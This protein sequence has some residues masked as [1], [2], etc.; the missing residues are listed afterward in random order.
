[1]PLS[2]RRWKQF[3]ES[4]Y[5]HE[6]EAL[7]FLREI[8]P[9]RD[10]IFLYSNFEFIAD[11]GSVNEIDALAVTQAGIFLIELKSRGG[12]VTGNRHL[13]DWNK[14][15]HTITVDSPLALTNSK[16]RKLAS[17]LGRQKSFRG[18]RAPWIEALVFLSAPGISVRLSDSE[19]MR[20]CEREP[21]DKKPGIAAALLQREYYGNESAR[22][23]FLDL[24][25]A[26]RFAKALEEAGIRP[27]QRQRRVGDY[28]LKELIEENPLFAYQDFQAE[29]PTTKATR[30]VRLY[31]V[32]GK[33][34]GTHEAV[35]RAALQEFQILEALDHPGILRAL[36]F[37]EHELGPAILFRRDS[38]EVRL[39]HFLRQ[40]GEKLPLDIRLNLVR[41]IADAVRYAHSH[42]VVHRTL[43]PKSILV[44]NPDSDRP[45][46]RLFNWQAGR[47]LATGSTP[48]TPPS[49]TSTL[50]PSQFSEE[51]MLC[52]LAPESV[53][54]PRGRDPMADVF[55]LGAVA[56]HIF[57][58][59]T[60]AMNGA[61]LNQILTEHKGLSLS[62]ALD[63]ANSGLQEL[64]REATAPDLL[65]RTESARDFLDNLDRA[66]NELTAPPQE[67][68]ADPL[69]ARPRDLLPH[70]LRVLKRLGGGT[71][72]VALLVERGDEILVLKYAR[73]IR[74][75]DRIEKE[76]QTLEALR[77][78][79]IVS[80]KGLLTFPNGHKGFLMEYAGEWKRD[81][82]SKKDA[83]SEEPRRDTLARELKAVG[84]LSLE[85]LGRFGDD[86]LHVVQYLEEKG[87]AHRDLKPDNIGIKEYG[88]KLHLK[89]FDFSLS[90]AP[91]ENVRVGTPPYLEP[92][93]QLRNRWDTAAERYSAAVILYEMATGTTP[94][95]GDGQSAPHL[96]EAPATIDADLFDAPVRQD[97]NDFF[98]RCFE[99]NPRQRFDNATDMLLAW[100]NIFHRATV[101]DS[102]QPDPSAQALALENLRPDTLLS[103]IG[104][105]TRAQN[106]LDRL[107]ILTAQELAAEP[108]G[109]F[110][111]L[112]GV[113]NKTRREI[114][115]LVGKLRSRL[116]QSTIPERTQ[117]E[118]PD[119]TSAEEAAI[120]ASVP[121]DVDSLTA[122]LIPVERSASGKVSRQILKE[123]LELEDV[124]SGPPRYP[125]QSEVADRTGK[126]LA[127]VSQVIIKARERW[128]KTVPQLTPVRADLAE[129]VA[130]QGGVTHISE[131]AQF[132]LASR[133]SAAPEPLASRRAAAV[134]RAALEAEKPSDS[135]QFKE[136]RNE[137]T[138]FVAHRPTDVRN[139]T[140]VELPFA[141]QALDYAIAVSEAGLSL[142]S[143]D[144][145]PSPARV[146]EALR[147]IP[148]PI[149]GLRDDRLVRIAAAHPQ[150]AVSPRL[151]LYPRN[152]DSLRALKLAQSSFAGIARI[153][154]DELRSRVHDR[155]PEAQLLPNPPELHRLVEEA[156]LG[157]KPDST[158]IVYVA[159]SNTDIASSTSL[160]RYQTIVSPF[161]SGGASSYLPSIEQ[162]REIEEA[163]EFERRL[164]A[165]YHAPSYLV[166]AT[167]PK[168]KYLEMALK[169]IAKHFPMDVFHCERAF[170][171]ALNREAEAKRVKWEVV[172][173]ADAA[174]PAGNG[175]VSRDWE[176]LRK[177]AANAAH[178][179][180]DQLRSRRKPT[181]IIYPGLLAR[182]GQLTILDELADSIGQHSLWLLAGSDRQAAS[183]MIDG[184][185]IPA[186][187]TQWGWIPPKWLDN[188]FRKIKGGS[189]A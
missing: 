142:A 51:S 27:S 108:P 120:E 38:T 145:L 70:G 133:G 21:R 97:L 188:E 141:E 68:L 149:P 134:V 60:P 140:T 135:C 150:V 15:G 44:V 89:I 54:D 7:E 46:V 43:S 186:R 95:W 90:N 34:K 112:R 182:Y 92:F 77:H 74:D 172:L 62:A 79:L 114:M 105:S 47:V 115:D 124:A 50:H 146:V 9:D 127:Q 3:A 156:G 36:D 107:G 116:P 160:H 166:L 187:P 99:R 163:I 185:A 35:R 130:A 168:V 170:L 94:R 57:S 106:T 126:A 56:F 1:M 63:G 154:A 20:I 113:G 58:A 137:N 144:P 42:R 61:E 13:W 148:T 30:R 71:C 91:L 55:S 82:S 87:V 110:S 139:G 64:V 66:E 164:K 151:E 175:Q 24:S 8:L 169:N 157:L 69:V 25:V 162:P 6:R 109:K 174:K 104:L 49:R 132:L 100:Q 76:Y 184:Q 84:R 119:E 121:L 37:S 189:A 19:R 28:V 2:V 5:P 45:E 161:P 4:Q 147:A 67:E 85:F 167:E 171:A 88:K 143:T 75:S 93:L 81:S 40:R 33:D 31:N 10:P 96:I 138:F 165:A 117:V 32:A 158:G 153:S 180:A 131:L 181:L 78:E 111:N 12:I 22:G 53:L 48:G 83:E 103:Q 102:R 136:R 16:A 129:F 39:D 72:A 128:R 65:L 52:Y 183:P 177:L 73:D 101:S 14:D 80:A 18:E 86:L 125:T 152:L 173:R 98:R 26:R 23:P 122:L 59:R 29:H 118:R 123:F 178:S 17:L 41:Q 11:D 159:P 179:V 176:N 155:Y